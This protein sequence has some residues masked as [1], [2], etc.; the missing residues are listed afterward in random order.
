MHEGHF[1][2]EVKMETKVATCRSPPTVAEEPLSRKSQLISSVKSGLF[3]LGTALIVFVAF[4]NTLT[5]HLQR[6]WGASGD[7]WQSQWVKVY[8]FFDGDEYCMN[9]WGTFLVTFAVYWGVGGLYTVMDLT[10]KPAFLLRYKIQENVPYP[11]KHTQVL[12]VI[13]QVL[14]NQIIMGIPFLIIG[15][16]FMNLRG[17]STG[18]ELPTFQWV[19][20]ELSVFILVEEVA[21]YYSHRVLHHPRFYKYIHKQHHEW[22]API[23]ITAIY[24]HPLEH[25]FSNVLP[26]FLG[27]LFM[28]SHTAT[29][30][31]WFTIAILSTL[32]AH[33]GYHFPFFP[34]PEAHDFHHLK[35]NQNY[36][37]LGV[38]D[39]FHGTDT[40]FRNSVIYDRHIMLLSLVPLKQLYPDNPKQKSM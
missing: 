28:G 36:G 8:Q 27:V 24:C 33:S 31:L 5:W 26:P 10:G 12:R 15:H 37:V 22:A 16:Y 29:C 3:I 32:N 19:L 1:L 2:P 13:K 40:L 23:A 39:R 34:S 4:R 11:V 17:Y 30:W 35:F 21:F 9:V 6:F 25:I 20:L 18:K 7:F 38:L 14:V